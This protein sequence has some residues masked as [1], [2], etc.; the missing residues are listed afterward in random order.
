[1]KEIKWTNSVNWIVN[2]PEYIPDFNSILANKI[3]HFVLSQLN[4][5]LKENKISKEAWRKYGIIAQNG[6]DLS[7]L[8]YTFYYKRWI[9]KAERKIKIEYTTIIN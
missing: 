7:G 3:K 1:M 2:G 4:D 9:K 6:C 5:F 8:S